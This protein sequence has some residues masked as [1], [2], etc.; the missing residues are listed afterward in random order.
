MPSA[1]GSKITCQNSNDI[2]VTI[3][4]IILLLLRFVGGL[5]V[6]VRDQMD[7]KRGEGR[8]KGSG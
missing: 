4:I 5:C 1:H 8:G 2:I 6:V 7:R 3:Y